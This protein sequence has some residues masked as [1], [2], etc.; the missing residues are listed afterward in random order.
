MGNTSSLIPATKVL[1][2]VASEEKST[3][4][5]AP[6]ADGD[7]PADEDKLRREL[8]ALGVDVSGAPPSGERGSPAN[9]YF[10][11]PMK[12]ESCQTITS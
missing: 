9:Q 3:G 6:L 4:K 8:E 11:T 12:F 5:A 7:V 1:E 10:C 2:L